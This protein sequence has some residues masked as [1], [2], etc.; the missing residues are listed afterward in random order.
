MAT[1]TFATVR[2]ARPGDAEALAGLAT[3]LG[4]PSSPGEL[5]ERLPH[6]LEAANAAVLVATD[7]ADRPVG[8]LHVE[9]K[10][11]LV[12][13][14]AAQVMGLVVDEAF[15][16]RGLGAELLRRAEEWA[17][18]RGCH[19]LLVATRV[20]REDAHRFY[21][22]EGYRLLKTSHVFEKDLA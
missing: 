10:H 11:S 13:P 16:D 15:R 8:W 1:G 4:Y 20:T 7:A 22:R 19:A 9:L 14:P 6:V 12:A 18:A 17:A 3:Q 21:R 5:T 2:P